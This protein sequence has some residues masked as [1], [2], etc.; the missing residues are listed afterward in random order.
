MHIHSEHKVHLGELVFGHLLSGTNFDDSQHRTTGGR[1]G[2][3][4]KL[5]NIFS[6]KFSIVTRDAKN[7]LEYRQ[8]W[9]RNMHECDPPVI[10]PYSPSQSMEINRKGRGEVEAGVLQGE[11]EMEETVLDATTVVR[12]TPDYSR[13]GMETLDSDHLA[14]F[15]RRAMDIAGCHPSVTVSFNGDIIQVSVQTLFFHKKSRV[16]CVLAN[17]RRSRNLVSQIVSHSLK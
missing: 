4:A 17:L 9:R 15:R 14:F 3:G 10:L 5:T 8:E 12:F 1:H 11:D 16:L 2:Y 7:K 6:E 13:F